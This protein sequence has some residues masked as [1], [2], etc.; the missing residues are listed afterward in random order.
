MSLIKRKNRVFKMA[1][2]YAFIHGGGQGGWVWQDTIA[3]LYV[4][5]AG[6][7]GRALALD[8][9]GCG[10]KRGRDTTQLSL[11]EVAQELIN[12]IDAAGMR[13]VVL[14]G[15]SQGGQVMALMVQL[16]PELFRRLIYVSCSIPLPGQTVIQ[17]MGKGVQGSNADEVGWPSGS[18]AQDHNARYAQLF[19]N[20]M[21]S[22]MTR[23][24]LASLDKDSWPLQTYAFTDWDTAHLEDVPASYVICL[25]DKILP[26]QWQETFATRFKAERSVR[27]D[28]GHQAMTSR[29]H[30]LAE[31][32][33]YEAAHE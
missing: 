1:V 25:R 19:C 15:H 4:Q 32:L 24:F 8:A 2:N 5:A 11:R 10:H 23:L 22:E 16:R 3:A 13:D 30:A 7:F 18:E 14:V 9:P 27:I 12:D 6:K 31:I 26:V 28:T 33:R 29:P 21:N 20:D 17:M